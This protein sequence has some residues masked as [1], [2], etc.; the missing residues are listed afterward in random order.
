MKECAK[1][2]QLALGSVEH[3]RECVPFL[4]RQLECAAVGEDLPSRDRRV[5]QDKLRHGCPLNATRVLQHSPL[6]VAQSQSETDVF[7]RGGLRGHPEHLWSKL[8]PRLYAQC[9]HRSNGFGETGFRFAQGRRSR[10]YLDS[11][12]LELGSPWPESLTRQARRRDCPPGSRLRP[13][14]GSSLARE[15]WSTLRHGDTLLTIVVR[16]EGSVP[17]EPEVREVPVRLSFGDNVDVSL[18]D[19]GQA[20]TVVNGIVAR[21][22][23]ELESTQPSA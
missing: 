18:A 16:T 12:E 23:L 4:S 10:P 20:R 22:S 5:L 19:I 13:H 9:T 7:G 8:M 14:G 15:C 21:A 11:S 1:T 17:G 2:R 3:T 6:A